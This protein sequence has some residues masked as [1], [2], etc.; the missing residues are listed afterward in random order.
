MTTSKQIFEVKLLSNNRPYC[1]LWTLLRP[2]LRI[3]IE[4]HAKL[5]KPIEKEA[6]TYRTGWKRANKVI[7]KY[8]RVKSNRKYQLRARCEAWV[9]IDAKL[10]NRTT[11]HAFL[12]PPLL[13]IAPLENVSRPR[14]PHSGPRVAHIYFNVITL[15]DLHSAD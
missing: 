8:I 14:T 13:S 6:I 9:S 5:T 4:S 3:F 11:I 12:L 7:S 2:D 10:I 15:V 1:S